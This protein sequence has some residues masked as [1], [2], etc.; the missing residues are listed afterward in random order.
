[1][2]DLAN[3][4]STVRDARQKLQDL[5]VAY[6]KIV[7]AKKVADAELAYSQ[8]QLAFVNEELASK[9]KQLKDLVE[10]TLGE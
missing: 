1:M 10:F 2:N 7:E 3:A 6:L 5:E 8:R 4:I 9:R